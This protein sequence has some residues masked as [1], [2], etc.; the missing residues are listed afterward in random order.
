MFGAFSYALF[1]VLLMPMSGARWYASFA[2]PAMELC[3]PPV[4]GVLPVLLSASDDM[5]GQKWLELKEVDPV[6]ISIR[7]RH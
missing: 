7:F 2:A 4:A 1:T 5:L 3:R 6:R